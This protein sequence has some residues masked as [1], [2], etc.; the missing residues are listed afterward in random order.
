MECPTQ[1]LSLVVLT[2]SIHLLLQT[3]VQFALIPGWARCMH[4]T[5]QMQVM[6]N[7]MTSA[8]FSTLRCL[9]VQLFFNF[10]LVLAHPELTCS[11]HMLSAAHQDRRDTSF[12]GALYYPIAMQLC[13]GK[14]CP[15]QFHCSGLWVKSFSPTTK[16]TS[17]KMRKSSFTKVQEALLQPVCSWH[18]FALL[19][20]L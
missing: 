6:K 1:W 18:L 15:S 11:C 16:Q 17:S 8:V 7:T 4:A 5:Q 10:L 13:G 9:K 14:V 3:L 12:S 19:V 2:L 20:F